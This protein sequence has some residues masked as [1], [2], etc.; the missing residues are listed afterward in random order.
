MEALQQATGRGATY[1]D[2]MQPGPAKGEDSK[3]AK[4]FTPRDYFIAQRRGLTVL[5]FTDLCLNGA[6]YSYGA[7]R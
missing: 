3:M 4:H 2:N 5:L 7:G 1:R 6:T